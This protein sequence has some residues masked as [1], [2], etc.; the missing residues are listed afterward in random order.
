M[1]TVLLECGFVFLL[2]YS[3]RTLQHADACPPRKLVLFPNAHP[4]RK[5]TRAPAHPFKR[6]FHKKSAGLSPSIVCRAKRHHLHNLQSPT[7]QTRYKI[8][9]AFNNMY[10]F[11]HIYLMFVCFFLSDQYRFAEEFEPSKLSEESTILWRY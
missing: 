4:L 1:K 10:I 7:P 9:A 5:A 11:K 2:L 3:F 6:K 8:C